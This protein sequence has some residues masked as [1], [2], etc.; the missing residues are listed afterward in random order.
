[1]YLATLSLG[2]TF[3]SSSHICCEQLPETA[4]DANQAKHAGSFF[5]FRQYLESRL[6]FLRNGG[7]RMLL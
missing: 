6:N 3:E 4:L 5:F 2:R 1:M 7:E